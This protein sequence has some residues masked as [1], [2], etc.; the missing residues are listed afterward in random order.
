MIVYVVL[1]QVPPSELSNITVWL[2]TVIRWSRWWWSLWEQMTPS[3]FSRRWFHL[4]PKT[5]FSSRPARSLTT[6]LIHES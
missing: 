1:H 3:W 6:A 2:Y 5:D 4:S